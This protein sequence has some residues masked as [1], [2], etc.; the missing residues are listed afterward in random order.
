MCSLKMTVITVFLFVKRR[1]EKYTL[2]H[3]QIYP[4]IPKYTRNECYV[5]IYMDISI[6][7]LHWSE[8]FTKK[9]DYLF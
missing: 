5:I 7:K 1:G 3:F 2:I 8:K 4:S 6:L 9:L